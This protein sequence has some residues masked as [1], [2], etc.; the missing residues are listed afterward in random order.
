MSPDWI[1]EFPASIVVTDRN[2]IVISMNKGACR[3]FAEEGGAALVGHDVRDCHV[4]RSG[5]IVEELF[6]THGLNAYTIEKNGVRKLI[7][8]CPWFSGGI[9]A[10]YVELSLPVPAEMPHYER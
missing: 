2:G 1:E 4:G 3:T 9:F 7:Y 6:E 10:G 5:K 8:Q